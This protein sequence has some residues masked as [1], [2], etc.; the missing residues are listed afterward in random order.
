MDVPSGKQKKNKLTLYIIIGLLAGVVLG[1]ALNQS[2]LSDENKALAEVD[3]HL[4]DLEKE[5]HPATDSTLHQQLILKKEA[6]IKSKNEIVSSRE[7]K[8]EP[9][10]LLADIFL[11]LIK[12]IV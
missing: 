7:K 8:V 12:M 10:A 11:R 2:Y 3:A 1:F 4:L 5:I 6:L 9:F